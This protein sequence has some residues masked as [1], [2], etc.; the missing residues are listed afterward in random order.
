MSIFIAIP[1]FGDDPE[2]IPTI[3][4]CIKNANNPNEIFLGV[5]IIG[6]E[7]HYKKTI[8]EFR[9]NQNIKI[10][11]N[12]YENNIGI[13][14]GRKLPMNFYNNEDYIL[15]IDSHSRLIKG[16]D[17]YLVKKH[18]YA[19]GQLKNDKL[20]LTATPAHY[21]YQKNKQ[22]QYEESFIRQNLGYTYWV[23]KNKWRCD[24]KFPTWSHLFPWEISKQLE[25]RL[26]SEEILPSTKVC[27]AFIFGNKLF[28]E[29]RGLD[30]TVLFWEEEIA[31]TCELLDSGFTFVYPGQLPVISHLYTDDI[32]DGIGNRK[33]LQ[34]VYETYNKNL[35]VEINQKML[36]YMENKDNQ[37]KLKK[38][39]EYANFYFEDSSCNYYS[40]P[41]NYSNI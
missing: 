29:N 23:E 34:Y 37:D 3:K 11:F 10:C 35:I 21:T 4:S 41:N 36:S 7:E 8:N 28:A 24:G 25:V 39:Q 13:G 12:E 1:C 16:W 2:L 5:S 40:F 9:N 22:G 19:V 17:E 30:E 20:I 15:Q 32:I 27:A 31:Q 6:D 38:F 18:K 26:L 33:S 14:I